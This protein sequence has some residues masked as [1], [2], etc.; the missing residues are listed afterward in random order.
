MCLNS[1]LSVI[2]VV[3]IVRPTA[4]SDFRL[5]GR[6]LGH[7]SLPASA[8]DRFVEVE[9]GVCLVPCQALIVGRG[10]QIRP[11]LSGSHRSPN[12]NLKK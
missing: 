6:N 7:A 5:A 8:V 4:H 1:V 12:P 9:H 3:E 10:E 2:S 11:P